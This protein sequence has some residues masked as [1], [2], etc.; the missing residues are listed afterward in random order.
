MTSMINTN[1]F[2][3]FTD[4]QLG[5]AVRGAAVTMRVVD[6]AV[7]KEVAIWRG[8]VRGDVWVRVEK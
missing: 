4:F 3:D 6:M 5:V 8:G 1:V 2:F 7:E